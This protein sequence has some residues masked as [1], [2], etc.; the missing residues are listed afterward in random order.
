M[1]NTFNA[2]ILFFS[3]RLWLT[4][5][6]ITYTHTQKENANTPPAFT[7]RSTCEHLQLQYVESFVLQKITCYLYIDSIV[8]LQKLD[9]MFHNDAP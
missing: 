8:L 7:Q 3:W 1:I 4:K 2:Y 9:N 5:T 6:A